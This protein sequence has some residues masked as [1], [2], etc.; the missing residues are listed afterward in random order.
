SF[1][2]ARLVN[3]APEPPWRRAHGLESPAREEG[4]LV[5]EAQAVAE[6]ILGVERPFSPGALEDVAGALAMNLLH[7]E[8]AQ[9]LR[10]G[11]DLIEV[12]DREVDVI[13]IGLRPLAVARGIHEREDDG[14]AVEVVSRAVDPPP[15][16]VQELR[17][18][19]G[20]LVEVGHL[21]GHTEQARCVSH[22]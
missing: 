12:L 14:P 15:L 20:G 1:I 19:D 8:A 10:P 5:D 2:L 17:I 4:P 21:Q 11:M 18:E 9:I 6:G 16:R 7:R 3:W 13:R 22:D